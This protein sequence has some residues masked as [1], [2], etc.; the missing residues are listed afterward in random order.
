[1]EFIKYARPKLPRNKYGLNSGNFVVTGGIL[2]SDGEIEINDTSNTT[3]GNTTTQTIINNYNIEWYNISNKIIHGYEY[4]KDSNGN[5]IYETQVDETGAGMYDENGELITKRKLTPHRD[6]WVTI[7][8]N[9]ES[10]LMNTEQYRFAIMRYRKAKRQGKGWRIPML[11]NRFWK[12]FTEDEDGTIYYPKM[13]WAEQ[14]TWWKVAGQETRWW[15]SSSL[16]SHYEAVNGVLEPVY[17]LKTYED[18]LPL[19][20]KTI[21]RWSYN[22]ITISTG[23]TVIKQYKRDKTIF[24][25][26]KSSKMLFGVALFKK[27]STGATGWQRVSNIAT[28]Q[29]VIHRNGKIMVQSNC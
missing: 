18:V 6:T 23:D 9:F 11:S 22:K 4:A 12:T 26:S 25:N 5:Y 14:D 2:S 7:I 19:D 15:A 1:M 20:T 13:T 17:R 27:T 28:M 10:K 3:N 21:E 16:I 29:L 8:E 24:K